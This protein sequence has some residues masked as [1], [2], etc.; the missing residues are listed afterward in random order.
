MV[1][2][3]VRQRLEH[4]MEFAMTLVATLMYSA[5]L[6][7]VWRA[8][9][10]H[11]A[12]PPLPWRQLAAYVLVGQAVN[13]ARWS[14]ADRAPVFAAARGIR[15]GAIA[16]DLV[17]P[18]SFRS[19]RLAEAAGFLAVEL[20]WVTLPA[21]VLFTAVLGVPLPPGPLP[22][23]VFAASLGLGFLVAFALDS[24]VLLSAFWTT[25]IHGAQIAKRAAM[26]ILSGTVIPF[27]FLPP[28]LLA[29]ASHLPFQAMA[30]VPLSIYTGRVGGVGMLVLLLQQA[31]WAALM[32]G[33][34]EVLWN[35]A[36]RRLEIYGG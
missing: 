8:V 26:E 12:H 22:A 13:L 29:I 21:M 15:T 25:N 19:Q 36:F 4:R 33:I 5:L 30:Y 31:G 27:A 14:P 35:F 18:V 6:Y 23:V 10:A 17:R 11:Q 24:I 9:Y 34:C 28:W 2:T 16:F 3:A 1:R 7:A 32:L 20:L